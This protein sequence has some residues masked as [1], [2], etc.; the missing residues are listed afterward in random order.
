MAK[1]GPEKYA[2]K[3][4]E[5]SQKGVRDVSKMGP[6]A[7]KAVG[8]GKVPGM[9]LGRVGTA[10]FISVGVITMKEALR[11]R[12]FGE[13]SAKVTETSWLLSAA[14]L[15]PIVGTIRSAGRLNDNSLGTSKGMRWAELGINVGLD[16]FTLA[17]LGTGAGVAAGARAML[18]GGTK[19]AT[20]VGTRALAK[21]VGKELLEEGTEM[22]VKKGAKRQTMKVSDKLIAESLAKSGGKMVKKSSLTLLKTTLR[23]TPAKGWKKIWGHMPWKQAG[24]EGVTE[25]ASWSWDKF[26][27]KNQTIAQA[28]VNVGMKKV[29]TTNQARVVNMVR[30][31]ISKAA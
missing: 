4:T 24:Y 8:A 26:G 20:K 9:K 30:G 1:W 15:L 5:L 14:E 13:F 2:C 31:G 23:K 27:P 10:S 12:S 29:L 21:K 17:T 3:M 11:S 18:K 25:G 6:E 22:V 16:I 28:A 19:V 7:I